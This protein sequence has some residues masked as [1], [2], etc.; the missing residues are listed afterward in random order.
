MDKQ[1]NT[2]KNIS[3]DVDEVVNEISS[4]ASGYLKTWRGYVEENP[5][6]SIAI[7]AATGIALGT[8]ITMTASQ[9]KQMRQ[10]H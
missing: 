9:K 7:A 1:L 4:K 5:F 2:I 8:F 3:H 10:L 6:I